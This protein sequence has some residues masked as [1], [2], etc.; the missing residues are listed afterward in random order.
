VIDWKAAGLGIIAFVVLTPSAAVIGRA[1]TP[2]AVAVPIRSGSFPPEIADDVAAIRNGEFLTAL[3][4]GE[5]ALRNREYDTALD[6]F[7]KANTAVG[8]TS[9]VALFEISRAYHALSAFKNEADT[10]LEALKHVGNNARLA[11]I[12]HNQRGLALQALVEKNVSGSLQDA[13]AEFRA[14]VAS[15]GAVPSALYNLGIVLLKQRRDEE[16]RAVLK[17]YV[18]MP[19]VSNAGLVDRMI[20]NPRRARENYGPDFRLTTL[21]GEYL[22]SEEFLGRTVL[23]DFWGTWCAPCRAATP[24]LVKLQKRY[25]QDRV[26]MVGISSDPP[27]DEQKV[28]DYVAEY[29]MIWPQ[30]IDT[31]RKIHNAFEVR[32]FPTYIVLDAEGIIRERV[33]GWGPQTIGRLEA[34][35]QKSLKG[36]FKEK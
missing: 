4:A 29:K 19:G 27:G 18:R 2:L 22:Q 28:R 12:L 3:E 10:C 8:K 31:A 32:T 17:A 15:S 13:E 30:N 24:E 5:R 25:A 14:A 7:R 20:E 1:Q 11:A 33:L 16:G 36:D 23:L 26:V 35:I 9:P 21:T 6:A 34:A